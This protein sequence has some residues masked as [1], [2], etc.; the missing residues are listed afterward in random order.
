MQ[1][2][3]T[4]NKQIVL[5][6]VFWR[7]R[8]I[9]SELDDL[10][11]EYAVPPIEPN[12]Y[13]KISDAIEIFPIESITQPAYDPMYEQLVGPSWAF[14]DVAI[15]TYTVT[16]R[17]LSVVKS[18]LKGLTASER[19]K[20]EVAGVKVTIQEQE[21][22][23]DTSR[24]G[25]NIFVQKYSMMTDADVVQWKFPS[26]WLTLTKADL[27]LVVTEG[28]AHVES[29]F[30]WEQEIVNQIEAAMTVDELK[31]IVITEPVV[32]PGVV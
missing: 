14:T 26:T 32:A 20:K 23:V 16:S 10:E 18:D 30:I 15:G 7:H 17:D 2:L 27:G 22:I 31:A 21:V 13:L 11:V 24:D 9:Q 28:A 3:L 19:Y 8:F 25:R 6:P 5:G 12:S 4:E 1:Y 29:Q